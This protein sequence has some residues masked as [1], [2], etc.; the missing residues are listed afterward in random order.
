MYLPKA[1]CS[2]LATIK[3]IEQI[4]R[5]VRREY[6]KGNSVEHLHI[7]LKNLKK[8]SDIRAFSPLHV[9]CG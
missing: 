9:V 2:R 6:K 5:E 8:E 4:K 1:E 7:I 3:T